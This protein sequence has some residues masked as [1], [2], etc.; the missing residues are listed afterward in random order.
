MPRLTLDRGGL[1]ALIAELR[2]TGRRVVGPVLESSVI[3]F[4]EITS[5]DDLPAGW[6]MDIG[7][8][9][10]RAVR[11]HDEALFGYVVG[12]NGLKEL[13]FPPRRTLWHATRDNG[14]IRFTPAQAYPAPTAVIG[15]RPCDLAGAAIQD[16]VF[17]GGAHRDPDYAARRRDLFVVAVNC[18]EAAPTCFCTSL[19][20]GPAVTVGFDIALT[21]ILEP[22]RH[23][24]VA[25]AGS[26][27]G[28][29]LLDAV[30]HSPT[31]TEQI[32]SARHAV[33]KAAGSITRRLPTE[34]LPDLL[35]AHQLAGRWN[36]T[37]ERCLACGNCTQVCPTCFCASTEDTQSLDGSEFEKTRRWDSCFTLD[38][39]YMG[40]HPVRA[41]I[42]SRYR[43]WLT[44]KLSS[45]VEQFGTLGCVGCGRCIVWCPVG[46]DLTEEVSA[47]RA[48]ESIH[49]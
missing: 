27:R 41:S 17:E 15:A 39:S 48:T 49:V 44:H 10:A 19:G 2:S 47:L 40:G 14:H 21:E 22:D 25:E 1:S 36:A 23:I 28:A 11:R 34:G 26:A 45:W 4:S 8:G 42:G 7:P 37:A 43:Q 3:R 5:I 20:T 24:F 30:P 13:L 12:P 33:A 18:T 46:I 38:F 16:R 35:A 29:E 6:T 32:T 9:R 31:T